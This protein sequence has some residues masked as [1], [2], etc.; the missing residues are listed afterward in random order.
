M[1]QL[2][3]NIWM[4]YVIIEEL[5]D[6]KSWTLL[7][8]T[9]LTQTSAHLSCLL[10]LMGKNYI[11]RLCEYLVR[12]TWHRSAQEKV[13]IPKPWNQVFNFKNIQYTFV[14]YRNIKQNKGLILT[15]QIT[16]IPLLRFLLFLIYIM[17]S[18]CSVNGKIFVKNLLYILLLLPKLARYSYPRFTDDKSEAH[19]V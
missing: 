7:F 1:K 16:V 4:H 14:N 12:S 18:V 3:K 6:L 10:F 9:C 13:L 19:T 15:A 5:Q 11:L 17:P 2:E 8:V